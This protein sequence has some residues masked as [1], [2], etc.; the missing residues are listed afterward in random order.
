M[1]LVLAAIFGALATAVVGPLMVAS[2]E[3]NRHDRQVKQR[4]EDLEEWIVSRHRRF[5]AE[6]C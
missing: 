6:A 2:V 1:N 5:C 3:A 4:D